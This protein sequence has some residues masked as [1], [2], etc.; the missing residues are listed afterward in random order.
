MFKM[1]T[2]IIA[3]LFRVICYLGGGV[4]LILREIARC[5][6][7]ATNAVVRCLWACLW[8][9]L[10][11]LWSKMPSILMTIF[12]VAIIVAAG[13]AAVHKIEDF[14]SKSRAQADATRYKTAFEEAALLAAEAA[15]ENGLTAKVRELVHKFGRDVTGG[16]GFVAKADGH[17][18][19]LATTD[20][21]V[22]ASVMID[23]ISVYNDW[24][25]PEEDNCAPYTYRGIGSWEHLLDRLETTEQKALDN[26][27]GAIFKETK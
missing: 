9:C 27:F 15:E 12:I 6:Y 25:F 19:Y 10:R 18:V 5:F 16:A 7:G 26:R 13:A 20:G 2:A 21:R 8:A 11:W 17:E 4:I 14:R 24:C 23:G 22:R 1:T 3:T